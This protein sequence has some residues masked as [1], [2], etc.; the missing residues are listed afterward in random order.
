MAPHH[1]RGPT[2]PPSYHRRTP[3]HH[4]PM[5][6]AHHQQPS[7]H[8]HWLPHH[9]HQN[10]PSDPGPT[11]LDRGSPPLGRR[12]L[13]PSPPTPDARP[14]TP[15]T[16]PP[17]SSQ[18]LPT[19]STGPRPI[20]PSTYPTIYS[21]TTG[22]KMFS[23]MTQS[24]RDWA[25][26]LT[27]LQAPHFHKQWFSA[28][29]A[30]LRQHWGTKCTTNMEQIRTAGDPPLL[31]EINNNIRLKRVHHDT[32]PTGHGRR[33]RTRGAHLQ[34]KTRDRHSRRLSLLPLATSSPPVSDAPP[35]R[36]PRRPPDPQGRPPAA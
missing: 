6:Q 17:G 22:W 30:I 3:Y 7:P 26:S 4:T 28:H 18:P 32:A 14:R 31:T 2:P 25:A 11:T 13:A 29:W 24:T 36:P 21:A 27:H 16:P 1:T 9:Q 12:S 5:G 34:A 10:P 33:I 19:A 15:A 8:S 35:I 20:S 23:T